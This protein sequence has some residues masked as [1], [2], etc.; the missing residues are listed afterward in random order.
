VPPPPPT[1]FSGHLRRRANCRVI[2]ISDETRGD[3]GELTWIRCGKDGRGTFEMLFP[4]FL[5]ILG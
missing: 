2:M 3:S 1:Q 4:H 5:E